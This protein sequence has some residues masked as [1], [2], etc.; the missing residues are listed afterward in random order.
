M[1]PDEFFDLLHLSMVAR[2]AGVQSLDDGAHVTEDARI[3]QCCA[4]AT[5]N[6]LECRGDYSAASN[7]MKLVH[8]PLMGGLL[9]LVQRGGAWAGCSPPRPLQEKDRIP[10]QKSLDFCKGDAVLSLHP[11][12]P[13]LL[14]L[15]PYPPLSYPLP[16]PPLPFPSRPILSFPSSSLPL[17]NTARGS[18]KAL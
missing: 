8:W 7:F 10:L 15:F 6:P 18:G 13:P 16:C 2:R 1:E 5:F 17:A 12:F 3:H 9:H 14:S 11:P 4:T